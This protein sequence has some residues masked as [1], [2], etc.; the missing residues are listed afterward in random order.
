MLMYTSTTLGGGDMADGVVYS[1]NTKNK[2]RS[3]TDKAAYNIRNVLLTKAGTRPN[4]PH[5][6]S[7]L[8]KLEYY[9]LDQILIDLAS[10]YIRESIAN[11]MDGVV[12]SSI[13]AIV[14][15]QE[16][17]ITFQI[18]FTLQNGITS[19]LSLNYNGEKFS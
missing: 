5:F 10:L 11:S 13:K 17:K 18:V 14:N 1:L 8:H 6:G 12:V 2:F 16:R 4:L 7:K 19:S 9:P 15:K 3:D